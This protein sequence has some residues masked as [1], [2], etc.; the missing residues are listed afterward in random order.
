MGIVVLAYYDYVELHLRGTHPVFLVT[1]RDGD[2]AR[3]RYHKCGIDKAIDALNDMMP[4][5]GACSRWTFHI[6]DAGLSVTRCTVSLSPVL[7]ALLS[8]ALSSTS[9]GWKGTSAAELCSCLMEKGSSSRCKSNVPVTMVWNQGRPTE[10]LIS[11]SIQ[12]ARPAGDHLASPSAARSPYCR[13]ASTARVSII[14]DCS[15][16]EASAMPASKGTALVVRGM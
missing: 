13:G 5:W 3:G 15:N 2:L 12:V 7:Y 8:S 16:R 9:H 14:L 6:C 1:A 11:L 4:A 10:T